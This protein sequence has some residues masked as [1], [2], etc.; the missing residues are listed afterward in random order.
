MSKFY[1]VRYGFTWRNGFDSLKAA[2]A[3]AREN[4]QG[5]YEVYSYEQR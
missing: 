1:G 3:W 5:F 4:A 2:V